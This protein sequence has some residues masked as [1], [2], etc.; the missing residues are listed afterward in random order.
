MLTNT[1]RQVV[2]SAFFFFA[3]QAKNLSSVTIN[4]AECLYFTIQPWIMYSNCADAP[5][6]FQT[7]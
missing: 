4:T 6:I 1:S 7:Y 2:L 5:E 3:Q